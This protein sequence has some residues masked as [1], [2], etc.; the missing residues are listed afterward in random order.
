M[1]LLMVRLPRG[2]ARRSRSVQIIR[3]NLVY[4]NEIFRIQSHL[5][6]PFVGAGNFGVI[7]AGRIWSVNH[8]RAVHFVMTE[9]D[10]LCLGRIGQKLDFIGQW[11]L[12]KLFWIRMR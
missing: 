5:A 6:G 1:T 7:E 3:A 9:K 12:R 4:Q 2:K 10:R 11:R 8:W